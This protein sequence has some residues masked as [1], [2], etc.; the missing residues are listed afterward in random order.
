[1][2]LTCR[3][4]SELE[5]KVPSLAQPLLDLHL[6]TVANETLHEAL[7]PLIAVSELRISLLL[8]SVC[9]SVMSSNFNPP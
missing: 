7:Q 8:P 1:M 9:L 6:P 4:C 5:M 2:L 3:V